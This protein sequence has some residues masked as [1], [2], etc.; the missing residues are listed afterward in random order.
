MTKTLRAK[1]MDKLKKGR[2]TVKMEPPQPKPVELKVAA[3]KEKAP[4]RRKQLGNITMEASAIEDADSKMAVAQM[5]D[6][7]AMFRKYIENSTDSKLRFLVAGP[8]GNELSTVNWVTSTK[9]I[10]NTI[11]WASGTEQSYR[12]WAMPAPANHVY[13][14]TAF[15]SAGAVTATTGYNVQGYSNLSAQYE[16]VS[17]SGIC[18]V[19]KALSPEL[20]KGGLVTVT[21][22]QNI[23]TIAALTRADVYNT[24]NYQWPP[25]S[26][27]KVRCSLVSNSWDDDWAERAPTASPP[28][29]AG[30]VLVEIASPYS[31]TGQ[32]ESY[33]IIVYACWAG[34]PLANIYSAEGA[35]G[36]AKPTPSC[37]SE[38][39]SRLFLAAELARLPQYCTE[40]CVARDG[41]VDPKSWLVDNIKTGKSAYSSFSKAF[42][43]EGGATGVLGNLW[44]GAK[45]VG[46]VVGNILSLFGRDER[47]ARIL[48]SLH[49]K[50]RRD[51]WDYVRTHDIPTDAQL[52]AVIT[53]EHW[54]RHNQPPDEPTAVHLFQEEEKFELVT[55]A[56][57]PR[58]ASINVPPR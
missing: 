43:G 36:T 26:T 18:V 44:D 13:V 45:A 29:G 41:M 20:S 12:L 46:S 9:I 53:Y 39:K 34:V 22:Y 23:A 30:C 21:N 7:D 15:D 57:R 27:E 50:N 31:A 52:D 2:V 16:S 54:K 51:L 6:T 3:P 42:S 32:V 35:S 37:V 48:R 19:V 10:A 55:P 11:Q 33:E 56:F 28:T 58:P 49:P 38:A 14:G 5:L 24:D 47:I 4:R 1:M 25:N 8:S 17:C 40:R